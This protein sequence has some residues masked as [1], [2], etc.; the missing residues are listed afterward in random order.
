MKEQSSQQNQLSTRPALRPEGSPLEWMRWI[1]LVLLAL[2]FCVA[3]FIGARIILVPMLSSLALAYLLAPVVVWFERRGWSRSSSVLLAITTATVT[4]VLILI[5]ILPSFWGQLRK[6][7]DQARSLVGDQP[8]VESLLQ[9]IEQVSPPAYE[10]LKSQVERYKDPA[11][12]ERIFGVAGGWFQRGL[13]RLVDVTAS[14]LDL[15]LIPFFVYYLL[16]DYGAMRARID[17]LI[18][19]RHRAVTSTLINRINFVISSYVRSQLVIALVMG[20]LYAIGFAVVRVPL[21]LTIGLLSGLL[22]FV[23]YLGTLTGLA[24]SLSFVALDG[25]GWARIIGVVAVF[26]I[27]Q[28]IE[29]YYLTPK[30]LGGSLDLHP[31]WVLVGLMIGGSLFGL[32][33]IILAV[34]VIAVA[35]VVLNFLEELYQ[36][37]DF[38]QD[39]NSAQS[40]GLILEQ[41]P[42]DHPRRAIVTTGELRSRIKDKKVTPDDK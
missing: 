39:S 9:K 41:S 6:T 28:S 5:F 15:L 24:L 36:Q 22:N 33:G 34:P 17:R 20:V 31:L 2:V 8:R 30:L 32:L 42:I 1:P 25:A 7:Y 10:F 29:G 3:I 27:V 21:A 14:L 11:Q 23:P 12:R 19:A 16:A 40:T 38:Y 35:K 4:L 37:S 13:F 18:P 26:I